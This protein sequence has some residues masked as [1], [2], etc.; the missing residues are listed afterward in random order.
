[1]RTTQTVACFVRTHVRLLDEWRNLAGVR[2]AW[3]ARA[4]AR[5]ALAASLEP[6]SHARA[7]VDLDTEKAAQLQVARRRNVGQGERAEQ[8][9]AVLQACLERIESASELRAVVLRT[10]LA[11]VCRLVGDRRV[12]AVIGVLHHV[13]AEVGHSPHG[14]AGRVGA[15]LAAA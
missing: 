5:R 8:L 4:P 1:N 11:A 6:V 10:G 14:P 7:V 12:E 9:F 15:C 13:I 3:S 2:R